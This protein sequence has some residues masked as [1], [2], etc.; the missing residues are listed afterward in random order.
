MVI[1][2]SPYVVAGIEQHFVTF[3]VSGSGR[4]TALEHVPIDPG[5]RVSRLASRLLIG[6]RVGEPNDG[7]R[8]YVSVFARQ[9]E[10]EWVTVFNSA[11]CPRVD[12][13][14]YE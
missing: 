4:R 5:R 11:D 1:R 13:I 10:F 2:A 8:H 3:L 14:G 6:R 9:V 12:L 7:V